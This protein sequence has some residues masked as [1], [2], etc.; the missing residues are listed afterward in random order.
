MSMIF[1]LFSLVALFGILAPV[2][3]QSFSLAISTEH[4]RVAAH[5]DIVIAATLTNLLDS[6]ILTRFGPDPVFFPVEMHDGAGNP[7]PDSAFMR[8]VKDPHALTVRFGGHSVPPRASKTVNVNINDL[9]D[10]PGPGTYSIQM[11]AKDDGLGEAHSN[12]IYVT[13]LP[14][15]AG[16]APEAAQVPVAVPEFPHNSGPAGRRYSLDISA[17]RTW[18][19]AG[20]GI[21]IPIYVTLNNPEPFDFTLPRNIGAF[22]NPDVRRADGKPARYRGPGENQ[23]TSDL[24]EAALSAIRPAEKGGPVPAGGQYA[25]LIDLNGYFDLSEPGNYFVQLWIK[26]PDQFGG[27]ELR[28]NVLTFT[29]KPR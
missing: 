20:S 5:D 8:R 19:Y 16:S 6:Y 22:C 13:V 28:S 11:A 18:A 9:F 27:G 26:I 3:A 21:R 10:V 4:P 23:W 25:N 17:D 24:T 2:Q 1:R 14:P 15:V 12:I 29:V 7:V